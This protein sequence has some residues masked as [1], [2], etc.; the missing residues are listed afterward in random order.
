METVIKIQP[1][2]LNMA[3][4]KKIRQFIGNKENVE[5]T[6]SLKESDPEYMNALSRSIQEAESSENLI[7]FTME[8]FVAY[9]PKPRD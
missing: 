3:L 6:I 1:S 2:E 5:V 9:N 8:E 7:S 4:L